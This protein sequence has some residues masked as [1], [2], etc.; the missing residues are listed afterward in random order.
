MNLLI[1]QFSPPCLHFFIPKPKY[2]LY[3]PVSNTIGLYSALSMG[4]TM[5]EPYRIAKHQRFA[6]CDGYVLR[7]QT[8]WNKYYI[9]IRCNISCHVFTKT[10]KW[11]TFFFCSY[12]YLI[13][14]HCLTTEMVHRYIVRNV[15]I[16]I[17]DRIEF[18]IIHICSTRTWNDT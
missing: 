7:Q 4:Q 3:Y 5:T 14:W 11:A 2:S 15:G 8:E 10:G 16:P 17:L 12:H 1:M 18:S 13:L 6:Y 9:V